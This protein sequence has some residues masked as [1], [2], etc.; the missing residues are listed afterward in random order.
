MPRLCAYVYG[1]SRVIGLLTSLIKPIV[2]AIRNGQNRRDEE[3]EEKVA[4]SQRRGRS[5]LLNWP[6][7]LQEPYYQL[8]ATSPY[9]AGQI[10]IIRDMTWQIASRVSN[11]FY[12]LFIEGRDPYSLDIVPY[13]NAIQVAASYVPEV[14]DEEYV[15]NAYQVWYAENEYLPGVRWAYRLDMKTG[16]WIPKPENWTGVL[17]W[18]GQRDHW[19]IGKQLGLWAPK[20]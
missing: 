4:T 3:R 13:Y 8:V 15:E 20:L 7:V 11:E 2:T 16:E 14:F 9:G 10:V 6:G 18:K 5:A 1:V 17:T 19:F 12:R